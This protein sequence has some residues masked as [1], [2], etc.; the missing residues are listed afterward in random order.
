MWNHS[1]FKWIQKRRILAYPKS[2]SSYLVSCSLP[3]SRSLPVQQKP[4]ITTDYSSET[5]K[6]DT[7]DCDIIIRESFL[8]HLLSISKWNSSR[9]VLVSLL[10]SFLL[11]ILL[12]FRMHHILYCSCLRGDDGGLSVAFK[13]ESS[14]FVF[15]G[16]KRETILNVK[17]TEIWAFL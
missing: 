7:W 1:T 14:P 10:L 11:V 2:S 17:A 13:E 15:Y 3:I 16:K 9:I 8:K 6:C 4:H 5:S 12:A